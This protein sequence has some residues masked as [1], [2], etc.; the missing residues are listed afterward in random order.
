MDTSRAKHFSRDFAAGKAK[1]HRLVKAMLVSDRRMKQPLALQL[2]A[3]PVR[4]P[5]ARALAQRAISSAAGKHIRRSGAM[6]RAETV[7]LKKSLPRL[8]RGE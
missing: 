2:E 7:A 1:P 8:L 6:R 5:V 4:N 3:L